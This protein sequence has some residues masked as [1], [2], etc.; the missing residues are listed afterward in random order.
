MNPLS[1][2]TY[3][4]RHKRN[5]LL[6]IILIALSTMA[7]FLMVAVLDSI[8]LRANA[9]Y[10]TQ[11]SRV[12]PLTGDGLAPGIVSQIQVHPDVERVVPENGLTIS[13]PVLL[14]DEGLDLLGVSTEDADYLMQ[15]AGMR[16]K[17][18]RMFET[19]TN[20][21][22]L[23]DAVAR[24]LNLEVG[25]EIDQSVDKRFYSRLVTPFIVVGIVERDPTAV[26]PDGPAPRFGFVAGE[27]LE[28]HELYAS[29]ENG[30]VVVP[31][32][33]QLTTLNE[34]LESTVA[35]D[36]TGV[37]TINEMMR[38][39]TIARQ[40]LYLIFGLVNCLVAVVVA[41]VMAAINQIA[42][43]QRLEELGVLNALGF[44]KRFLSRRLVGETAVITLLG[45]LAGL[46][47]SLVF[48]TFLRD[49]VLYARGADLNVWNLAPFLFVIPIPLA[50]IL[51]AVIGVRRIFSRLDAVQILERGNLST[52]SD[53]PRKAVAHSTGKP[54]SSLTY[55]RRHRRRGI[56]L[57][58]TMAL[59]ILGVAFPAFL[60]L[61]AVNA[62]KPE[63]ETWRSMSQVYPVHSNLVDAG[64][65]AQIRSHE[66][67]AQV[68][69]AISLSIQMSVPPGGFTSIPLFGVSEQDMHLLIEQ[70]GVQLL[71]GQLPRPRSNDLVISEAVA[72]NRGLSVGDTI[73]G[74][75][76]D[77]VNPLMTDNIPA[78]MVVAGIMGPDVPWVGLASIEFL[79]SHELT[80]GYTQRL[81]I[82]PHLGREQSLNIWLEQNA[83]TAFTGVTTYE[84]EVRQYEE[85][86][87]GISAA[88]VLVE[89]LIA[90]VAAVALTTLNTI[91][92]SQRR[93]EFGI[94]FAIGRSRMWLVLRTLRETGSTVFIA[95]LIGA[96]LCLFGLILAQAWIY[97][98]LGLNADF[99]NTL[100]WLFTL[101]IPI[102]VVLVSTAAIGRMLKK[103]DP[104][105]VVERR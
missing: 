83:D 70:L 98:P 87:T 61:T 55:Y 103:L 60:M 104:I 78:E 88:F 7:L 71:E 20:E 79:Q 81:L 41:L 96:L 93:Q 4:R 8:P 6:L 5:T 34:F 100:P 97:T 38:F 39:V 80:Q 48:L 58:V 28:S 35:S 64:L 29:G 90:V 52:E 40:S 32:A 53:K 94:L 99:S 2:F 46:I 37:L 101:P 56:L 89:F 45:W 65:A 49:K 51:S 24:A 75:A 63:I 12:Y 86:T 92:Y 59:M 54:L 77:D 10:L 76:D 13:Y 14:G 68:V 22:V 23:S 67:V 85:M 25:D 57:V 3:Y 50:V 36:Y 30:L 16:L 19:R 73:G 31:K 43:M 27:Y 15:Y 42:M 62:M 66:D 26:T 47:V 91:F 17:N 11:V 82:L 1:P 95:W 84:A 102:A 18:G 105:A 21:L 72:K 33:N 74:T 44:D 9:N 69:P